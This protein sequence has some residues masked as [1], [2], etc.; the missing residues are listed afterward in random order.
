MEARPSFTLCLDT[1]LT[2]SSEHQ[3][4]WAEVLRVI[5][6]P[7]PGLPSANRIGLSME[8]V[9]ESYSQKAL[10]LCG[11][12]WNRGRRPETVS[13]E[14]FHLLVWDVFY[15]EYHIPFP[16]SAEVNAEYQNPG[17]SKSPVYEAYFTTRKQAEEWTSLDRKAVEGFSSYTLPESCW[18]LHAQTAAW[19][20]MGERYPFPDTDEGLSPFEV[21]L[22]NR[23]WA[24]K[25][26]YGEEGNLLTTINGIVETSGG[27]L[28]FEPGPDGRPFTK[29][30]IGPVG[31]QEGGKMSH[32]AILG[33][34]ELW[35][36][37]RQSVKSAVARVSMV[38]QI[39]QAYAVVRQK[40][41]MKALDELLASIATKEAVMQRALEVLD[42]EIDGPCKLA[43]DPRKE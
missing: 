31:K 11:V 42:G 4:R 41:A 26:I 43:Q 12:L 9:G 17:S 23:A 37:V 40:G 20:R 16:W 15:I 32:D 38:D 39:R 6:R 5:T 35:I 2:A 34:V 1:T 10:A 28:W 22:P 36:A 8:E 25:H 29:L 27:R 30:V 14:L 24:Y 33:L 19:N 13:L 7:P 21:A 3:D 18:S